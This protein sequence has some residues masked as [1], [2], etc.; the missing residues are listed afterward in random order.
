MRLWPW[1]VPTVILSKYSHFLIL[2]SID[3]VDNARRRCHGE[4]NNS[5]DDGEGLAGPTDGLIQHLLL[6]REAGI[7]GPHV[8]D[9]IVIRLFTGAR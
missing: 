4:C 9:G 7:I 3:H 2:M 5:K 6:I 8:R 1:W